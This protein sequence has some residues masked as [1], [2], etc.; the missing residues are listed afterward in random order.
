[1]AFNSIITRPGAQALMPEEYSNIVLDQTTELSAVMR[2]ASQGPRMSRKTTRL[3]VVELLPEAG[4]VDG[5]NSLIPT[6]D[7]SWKNKSIEA[8][9]LGVVVPIPSDVFDDTEQNVWDTV[10]PLI[11]QAI[12]KAVDRAV[13]YGM[14]IPA[15]FTTNM[16][17]AGLVAIANAAG[18][19][20]S[21]DSYSDIYEAIMGESAAALGLLML[22]E[23]DG[24]IGVRA[25]LD[26]YSDCAESCA[27]AGTRTA[28]LYSRLDRHF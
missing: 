26:P 8:E 28:T 25:T 3:P 10:Q 22:L 11:S 14:G 4:F 24:F 20:I 23:E 16:G 13:L 6:T 7:M 15:S 1:M 9:K 27:T 17:G 5:D 2:L 12:G 18:Q 19:K 21:L